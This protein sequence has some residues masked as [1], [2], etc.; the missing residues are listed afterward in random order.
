VLR[1]PY[2]T[3][4]IVFVA[5]SV[6]Y[7]LTSDLIVGLLT[8]HM[9]RD[10]VVVINMTK[11]V[12][13]VV[14]SG[15]M[16]YGVS[17]RSYRS[18]VESERQTRLLF[19]GNPTPMWVTDVETLRFLDVND[20]AVQRYGYSREDFLSKRL[21]DIRPSVDAPRFEEN[22][23]QYR[24]GAMHTNISRHVDSTGR[25]FWVST[26]THDTTFN[27]R[28]ARI[29][30]V[31]DLTQIAS[32]PTEDDNDPRTPVIELLQAVAESIE[33]GFVVLDRE[34]KIVH[35]NRPFQAAMYRSFQELLGTSIWD[36]F[37]EHRGT[38]IE[39]ALHKGLAEG[40]SSSEET[41]D[42]RSGTWWRLTI[43]PY[44]SGVAMFF[45]D[46]T[47]LKRQQLQLQLERDNL[48]A[49]L[50]NTPDLIY[51]IDASYHLVVANEPFKA[52]WKRLTGQEIQIGS[53]LADI[54]YDQRIVARFKAHID[55]ALSGERFMAEETILVPHANP[56]VAEISYNPIL[57]D[58]RVVAVSCF[59]RDVTEQR[60]TQDSLRS[61]MAS[62]QR[63][64]ERYELLNLAT[65]DAVWEWTADE[66][67]TYWNK[68]L[69][70]LFGHALIR[71]D[72]E[73][74]ERH[75]HPDDVAAVQ[76]SLHDWITSSRRTW[77]QEYR[78]RC[79]DDSYR[80]VIDRG[81]RQ[82]D[83]DGNTLRL[84]GSIVD[85]H[86]QR[87]QIERIE[88]QN[89]ALREVARISAHEIRGPLTSMMGLLQLLQTD[90]ESHERQQAVMLML[91]TTARSLD[92]VIHR[93]VRATY[94]IEREL[95][96]PN[97]TLQ[98]QELA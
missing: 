66:N 3:A 65:H 62:L 97:P 68:G 24:S 7:I 37:P 29:T 91:K 11:G 19:E 26:H 90:D 25:I 83:D 88:Q 41:L 94:D 16:I 63:T 43:Y 40:L 46:I 5:V 74:W 58:G 84:I 12:T 98:H 70:T 8:Q 33:D 35:C 31:V 60:A 45:R 13:F 57:R 28:K 64:I 2:A 53:Y 49:I 59:S 75:I 14:L 21:T 42:G 71:T 23:R 27:D 81:L 9:S 1:R 85:V 89:A 36:L 54:A 4:A 56:I 72:P 67:V 61:S 86:E 48:N 73:W 32:E 6:V 92:E 95:D 38:P 78:F 77:S 87:A 55:R 69:E 52:R 18:I 30:S 80:W 10:A 47:D 96:L 76:A 39:Y 51:A 15:L 17:R 44:R 20:A 22:V 79:A 82:V 34:L 50:N 93:L